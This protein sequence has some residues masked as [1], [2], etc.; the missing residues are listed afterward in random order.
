[1]DTETEYDGGLLNSNIQEQM[2]I[3]FQTNFKTKD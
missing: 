3:C 1:M 2:T